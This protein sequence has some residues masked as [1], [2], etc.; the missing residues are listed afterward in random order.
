MLLRKWRTN[1]PEVLQ[2]IPEELREKESEDL[3]VSDPTECA[4]TLGIHWRTASDQFFVAVPSLDDSPPTKRVV[5]SA[6]ARFY[7]LM[8]WFAPVTLSI[9]VL[10][11]QLWTLK[12]DWDEPIPEAHV[13]KWKTWKNSLESLSHHPISRCF[14]KSDSPI[15]KMTL[16][17]F[18]DASQKGY[19]GVVYLRI[20]YNDTSVSVSLVCSKT[21]VAPLQVLTIPKLEL[22]GAL[23]MA[24]LLDTVA[25]DLG[26]P[27]SSLYAWTDSSVVL[28]W[29]SHTS[30]KWKVFVSN[31]VSQIQQLVPSQQWRHVP[32]DHNPADYA[33]RGLLPDEILECKLWWEGPSWL[34]QPPDQWPAPLP[35]L[36]SNDLPESRAVVLTVVVPDNPVAWSDFSSLTHVLRVLSWCFRFV[37]RARQKTSQRSQAELHLSQEELNTTKVA[38]LRI[39][40]QQSFPDVFDLIQRG[41]AL[42]QKHR[43]SP[44]HPFIGEDDLLRVGGRLNQLQQSTCSQNPVILHHNSCLVRMLCL[45]VHKKSGHPGPATLLT[46]LTEEY[47]IIG[48]RRLVK[49]IS[50]SCVPC[51]KAYARV[52][53]QLMGQLPSDR[54]QPSSPFSRVGIDFAGPFCT[55]RGNPRRPT[56][57]KT[58]A[59]LF[60]C[61][62]TKAIHIEVCSDLSTDTFIAALQR[63]AARRGYPQDIYSDNGRNFLGA[64][65]ELADVAAMLQSTQLRQKA[66]HLA[67]DYNLKWHFIPARSPHFG[68]LWEAGVRIMKVQLRKLVGPHKLTFEQLNTVLIE[69]ESILNSRPLIPLDLDSTEGPRSLTPG[70]FLIGRPLKAIPV[71]TDH[72]SSITYLR[73]WNLVKR[74]S[75]E[76]WRTWSSRYLQSLQSRSKWNSTTRSFQIGDVVLLKDEA[77]AEDR[78][79]PLAIITETH[80]GRDGVVRVVDLRIRGHT[81]RRSVDRLV[82]LLPVKTEG[83]RG[84]YVGDQ[85]PEEGEDP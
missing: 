83:D 16:H 68:G 52:K 48:I 23:L 29:L 17:G 13:N 62:A 36:I 50:K 78:K 19:G 20:V 6:I 74:L 56:L 85:D 32:T 34:Q 10:L 31:R 51:Q 3:I 26:L 58:Y 39:S 15:R 11:Q 49:Q 61:L 84:E 60:V 8:G 76:L 70:H 27:Q 2:A 59:C 4:K 30:S 57:V 80:P 65:K 25:T 28:G 71:R 77:L 40:Q 7:D 41:K 42:P 9:K 63:F 82:L 55:T 72:H 53:Q 75:S 79:W 66:S 47:Y 12:L 73:R 38:V 18:A 1:H 43:L 21:K 5:S 33:S 69:V 64:S 35:S 45:Q 67:S 81:Y 54:I 44:L 22:S 37:S 46:L 24:R 14:L